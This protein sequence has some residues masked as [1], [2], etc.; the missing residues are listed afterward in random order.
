MGADITCVGSLT[1]VKTFASRSTGLVVFEEYVVS[2]SEVR[3]LK[4][5]RVMISERGDR[6]VIVSIGLGI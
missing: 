5:P 2:Q 3:T 6:N 1:M 4:S